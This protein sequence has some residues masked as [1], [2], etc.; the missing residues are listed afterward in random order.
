MKHLYPL[1]EALSKQASS[2]EEFVNGGAQC[3]ALLQDDTVHS[4]LLISNS[5]AIVAM[6]G[7]RTL[8][9]KVETVTQLFQTDEDKNPVA[10]AGW[11]FFDD[12]M[13]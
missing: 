11:L 13:R 7:H 5:T 10:R 3:H 12:W 2:F 8:P 4:G 9:F 1:G 6:R